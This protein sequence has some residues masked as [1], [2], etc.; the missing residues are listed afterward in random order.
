MPRGV[1]AGDPPYQ[2]DVL[3][4]GDLCEFTIATLNDQCPEFIMGSVSLLDQ[5]RRN[6]RGEIVAQILHAPLYQVTALTVIAFS[7]TN[8]F[9]R[10][11]AGA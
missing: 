8:V 11:S 9:E 4:R 6:V 2:P 7:K 3:A 5:S 1:D 10:Q